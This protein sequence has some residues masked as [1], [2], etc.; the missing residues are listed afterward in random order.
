MQC[1][2]NTVKRSKTGLMALTIIGLNH[3]SAI[4]GGIPTLDVVEVHAETNSLLGEANSATQGIVTAAQLSTRPLLRPA[5]VLEIVPGLIVTQHS[6]DGKANQYF[7]RGFN[8]DH[9]TDFATSVDG[10]PVN[11]PTHGHGQG[12]SDLNFMIPELVETVHYRKG[13]YMAEDGDFASAGAADIQYYWQLPADI[14]ELT[15]GENHYQR[16]VLAGSTALAHQRTLLYALETHTNNGPWQV[17]EDLNKINGLL[18][19]SQGRRENGWSL[20]AMA[21][22]ADWRATDQIPQHSIGQT[23]DRF[24]SLD[25]SDG[26]N[27]S[28]YSLSWNWARQNDQG[29]QQFSAYAMDYR[30]DL[31][32]NFSYFLNDPVNGDQF[33]QQD[34]RKVYGF[35]GKYSRLHLIGGHDS[36]STLGLE[37][38]FDDID[39]VGL[40][41]TRQRQLLTSIR[42]DRVKQ[43]LTGIYGQ[44]Q[45]QWQ[46][47][48]RTIA[49]L[50]A[51][52][53]DAD[54]NSSLAAN[55]G[56]QQDQRISPKLSLIFG[57]WRQT[58]YY[59][60][61]GYGFHSNDARGV[62][63]HLNPDPRDAGFMM[64]TDTVPALVRTR[65]GEV[66]LRSAAFV[67]GLQTTLALWRLDSDSELVFVGDAGTTEANRPSRRY[68]LEMSHYY[69]ANPWLVLDADLALS[70]ARYQDTAPEGQLIP[71]AIEKTASLGLALNHWRQWSAGLRLRYLGARPLLEDDSIRSSSSALTNA[72]I[73]YQ[74]TAQWQ[75]SL[76]VLNL[77]DKTVND[78]DY[79]YNS[80]TGADMNDS[81]CHANSASRDGIADTHIHPAEARTF[82]LSLRGSW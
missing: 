2:E 34:R 20:S 41:L 72:K 4:A 9:G 60:N 7:L 33:H 75:S 1:M 52:F 14:A 17:S 56:S 46:P 22:D 57:P 28:R 50:R 31:F 76:E 53:F 25:S 58:E 64:A 32:S 63:T 19:L 21:Y 59:V 49:G 54:V 18:R 10:M 30:L 71:G 42:Q 12:Y 35:D 55:S 68:G 81:R 36:E 40:S 23:I 78:I 26:G 48:L 73:S 82:R 39:G 70:R 6:G 43:S 29:Q 27:S 3:H 8:L 44:N 66:G 65:S 13:P 51:D 37:A 69:Q 24:G 15:L 5:E 77:F 61:Y 67:D 62:T 11:M 80:C 79:F 47:W 16:G 74:W 45:T 38:R